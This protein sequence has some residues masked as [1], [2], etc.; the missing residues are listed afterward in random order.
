VPA[1]VRSID[2]APTVLSAA[3][4]PG[5]GAAQGRTLLPLI[6]G[7]AP[8]PGSAY[9]ETYFPRLYMNWAALRSIQDDRWKF[10]DAPAPELFDLANDPHEIANLASREP[11]RTAAFKRAF[12]A[13]TAGGE[14]SIAPGRVDRETAQK[15]AALG[16][17]GAAVERRPADGASRPDPKDMIGVFNHIRDANTAIQTHHFAEAEAA[18]QAVLAS[19]SSNAFAIVVL[20]R[21]EMEQGRYRTAAADYRRYARLVPSSADAHHWIA[22]CLSRLGEIDRALAEDEAAIAID[23][24]HAEA[25]GLRGGLLVAVGRVEEAVKEL[26]AAVEIVPDNVPFRVGF[27]RVLVSAGRLD[28]AE[29]EIHQALQRQP[30]NPDAL[31]ASGTLLLARKEPERARVAFERALARR[32]DAD[33]VRLDYAGVLE[34]LGRRAEARTEFER[35]ASGKGTPP[36]IRQAARDR[37]R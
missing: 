13:V 14:G 3:G 32:A 15:L 30:D 6:E 17:I 22:V 37:L 36:A 19:D 16:Y 20:A 10:I 28:E 25:H 1:V 27:G 4:I 11:A 8:G 23:P 33:D 31:A 5:L 2:L 12:E 9:S 18:A 24:R 29:A 35:L 21:A 7:R 34:Q 26:R